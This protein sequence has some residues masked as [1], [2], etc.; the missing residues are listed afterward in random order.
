MH[1][2]VPDNVFQ[3]QILHDVNQEFERQGADDIIVLRTCSRIEPEILFRRESTLVGLLKNSN[4][5]VFSDPD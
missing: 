2:L 1:P 4:L 5:S 3:I